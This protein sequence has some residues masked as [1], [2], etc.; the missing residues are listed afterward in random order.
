MLSSTVVNIARIAVKAIEGSSDIF[1][2]AGIIIAAY[3]LCRILCTS[4]NASTSCRTTHT[5]AGGGTAINLSITF[6]A[7]VCS[8]IVGEARAIIKTPQSLT[9]H[10]KS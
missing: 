7:T 2:L 4:T 1:V 6:E 10:A 3:V 9:E 8:N 5:I